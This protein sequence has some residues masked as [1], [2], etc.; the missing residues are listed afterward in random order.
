M[1]PLMKPATQTD[2]SSS[3]MEPNHPRPAAA[4]HRRSR[5]LDRTLP[6]V[7]RPRRPHRCT[8]AGGR[9]HTRPRGTRPRGRCSAE[10][11][12]SS[13]LRLPPPPNRLHS[14]GLDSGPDAGPAGSRSPRSCRSGLRDV[15]C[16]K[17]KPSSARSEK[18]IQLSAT[19]SAEDIPKT[20]H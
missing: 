17:M 16:Q 3:K 10:M 13:L 4:A 18:H 5:R 19:L 7:R 9:T 8:V 2:S 14:S 1:K 20:D 15:S 11:R 12:R 6:S